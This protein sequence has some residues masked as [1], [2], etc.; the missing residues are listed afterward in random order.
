MTKGFEQLARRTAEVHGVPDLALAVYPGVIMTDGGEELRDKVEKTMVAQVLLGLTG[1]L[2]IVSGQAEPEQR[3]IVIQGAFDEVQEF[4]MRNLWTEGLPIVPPTPERVERFLRFTD[5]SP[6]EVI[7]VLGPENREATVWNVAVNGVI[8]GCRPE[9]M[10]VLLAVVDTISDPELCVHEAGGTP[11]PEPM[12]MLNGPIIKEL[13][14]NCGQGV[15]KVGRQANTSVAR[16]LKLYMRN[17]A[18]LRIGTFDKGTIGY[19]YNLVLAEN[20]DVVADLGWQPFSVDQG[21]QSGDNVV[22]VRSIRAVTAPIYSA[23]STARECAEA[24]ADILGPTCSYSTHLGLKYRNFH[25]FVV[26]SPSIAHVLVRDGWTKTHLREFLY[27]NCKTT[28]TAVDKWLWRIGHTDFSLARMLEAGEA[29]E[30]FAGT[31]ANRLVPVFPQADQIGIV[32]AGD[33]DRNQA[34]GYVPNHPPPVSRK[35]ELPGRWKALL[36]STSR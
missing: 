1:H 35:I 19:T 28:A 7:G 26:I 23:G 21:F 25:P 6:E 16:F 29:P 18:G 31:N 13:D 2:Q 24:I 33:P 8:A 5:R 27:K 11:G 9:Y 3:D 12:I 17:I 4:F 32:I 36:E 15:M 14:F 10:P 20:E 22:T 30:G 34:R